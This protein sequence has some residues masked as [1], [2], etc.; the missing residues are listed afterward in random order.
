[1]VPRPEAPQGTV[2]LRVA[3][4]APGARIPTFKWEVCSGRG[5]PAEPCLH[6][7]SEVDGQLWGGVIFTFKFFKFILYWW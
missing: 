7:G 2:S 4:V 6:L 5:T 1:M 3:R